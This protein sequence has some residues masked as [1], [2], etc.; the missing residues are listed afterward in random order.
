MNNYT[1]SMHD[2]FNARTFTVKDLCKGFII[3]DSF[4]KLCSLSNTV[5]IGPR[6]SGKTT[7]MRMLSVEALEVWEGDW[8]QYYRDNISYSGVF[9]P[10][11]R[12]WKSQYEKAREKLGRNHDYLD[13]LDSL[14]V[15]HVLERFVSVVSFRASRI[16][17]KVNKFQHVGINKTTESDLVKE[18][19]DLWKVKPTLLSLKNL[20]VSIV[21]KKQSVAS[22]IFSLLQRN[23]LSDKPI[24][25]SGD[26]T[27]I[28]G[29]SVDIVNIYFEQSDS[30]WC[31]LFD[32]LELAP[33]H[34]VQPLVDA[35]R[36]RND[37]FILK[38][39]L[40]PYH[41]NVKI[42][43]GPDSSMNNQDFSF[44]SLTSST[45][46]SGLDF[47]KKLCGNVFLKHGLME[48]VSS[49]FEGFTDTPIKEQFH[50]LSE[51]DNS[52]FGYLKSQ[53][54]DLAKFDDYTDK[55]KKT[56]IR[57]VQAVVKVRNTFMKENGKPRSFKRPPNMYGGFDNICKSLEYN[58]RM[59]IGIMND[60][61]SV[62]KENRKIPMYLQINSI[63]KFYSSY[64]SLLST[65]A[66]ESLGDERFKNISDLIEF[67]GSFFK[68]QIH[69]PKF[70]P[71]PKGS[72]SFNKQQSINYQGAIGVALNAG[73]L[74]S[75]T[76][77]DSYQSVSDLSNLR[78]RLSYIFSH[79]YRTLLI[80]QRAIGFPE[81]LNNDKA[82]L[83]AVDPLFIKE[84]DQL[85]LL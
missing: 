46:K 26:I 30:K 52:F 23:E 62:A 45:D 17:D 54:I 65:I 79:H 1:P 51:K 16:I 18:L 56:T 20:E 38:L 43:T 8:A 61:I 31:F 21:K 63:V 78:C 72:L 67:I 25:L 3:S 76:E 39:A 48:P 57:K 69:G 40:S 42:T 84:V 37:R 53:G 71:E 66:I 85:D 13:L 80:K 7:L 47:S 73:A 49:Y 75:I 19:A 77:G 64:K 60:F 28:I 4:K 24:V 11:D 41:E 9:I 74:I 6:G 68:N 35:T 5:M 29:S 14:F 12:V 70:E 44:V 22:F 27:D 83:K 34:I 58:P 36:G 32:E 59:L 2:A 50:A 81:V 10:T 55:D 15:Y 82:I 33:D